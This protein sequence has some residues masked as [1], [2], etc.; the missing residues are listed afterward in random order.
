MNLQDFVNQSNMNIAK[1]NIK[2]DEPMKKYTT[3]KIGGPAECLIKICNVEDLKKIQKFANDN[4]I[5]ITTIG[6][7]SNILVSDN[8]IKGIVLLNRIESIV[9]NE[10]TEEQNKVEAIIGSGTKM[11]SIAIKMLK[12]EITGFEE[13]SGIPGTIGGAVVMNAGAHEKEIKDILKSVKCL[14]KKGN[15]VELKKEDLEFGYRHSKLKNKE[16][17][18]IEVKLLLTKG[19]KED[20]QIKMQEYAK[21]RKEKQPIEFPSAGSVFKRGNDY[22]TAKLIDDAKLKG[23]KIGGAEV[24]TKHSGFIINTGNATSKDVLELIKKIKKDVKEKFNKELELEIE[25]IEQ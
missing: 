15:I 18:V 23:Y 19:K 16:Y 22:I 6:N 25:V 12:N 10:D 4:N 11:A 8:G 21:Y 5:K 3:F 1:D 24:A 14:D 2:F 7:G 13:L 9:L 20:I 17:I